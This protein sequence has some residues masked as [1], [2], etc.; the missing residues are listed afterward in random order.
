MKFISL[1]VVGMLACVAVARNDDPFDLAKLDDYLFKFLE[2]MKLHLTYKNSEI[3]RSATSDIKTE[4]MN[5]IMMVINNE[6]QFDKKG[7][8]AVSHTI[9]VVPDFLRHCEGTVSFMVENMISHF[10]QFDSFAEFQ[11]SFTTHITTEFF[12]L[13]GLWNTFKTHMADNNSTGIVYVAGQMVEKTLNFENTANNR[14]LL[15]PE[16]ALQDR[17]LATEQDQF[18]QTVAFTLNLLKSVGMLPANDQLDICGTSFINIDNKLTEGSVIYRRDQKEGFFT[19]ADSLK[20]VGPLVEN[21]LETYEQFLLNSVEYF[22]RVPDSTQL[23]LNVVGNF[24]YI[25][26]HLARAEVA[27]A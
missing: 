12:E 26:R 22:G 1:V 2:G 4:L 21:C 6:G 27:L 14:L 15:T 13:M 5:D 11:D 23:L 19:M 16:P 24:A 20:E 10:S 18:V 25:V 9:S 7:I 17:L 3:C 8:I